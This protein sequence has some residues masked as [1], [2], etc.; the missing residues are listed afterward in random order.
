MG[1]C[2]A[3][4]VWAHLARSGLLS[5]FFACEVGASLSG[6][7]EFTRHQKQLNLT[8]LRELSRRFFQRG[9]SLAQRES[10]ELMLGAAKACDFQAKLLAACPCALLVACALHFS[11]DGQNVEQGASGSNWAHAQTMKRMRR[12]QQALLWASAACQGREYLTW[13]VEKAVE[14]YISSSSRLSQQAQSVR[15]FVEDSQE[16]ATLTDEQ[17]LQTLADAAAVLDSEG[18]EWWPCRGTLIALLRHGRRSGLLSNGKL[19]VVDHDVDI[20]VGIPS[21]AEW[22]LVRSSIVEK[23]VDRGWSHCF[24]RYSV[25]AQIGDVGHWLAR[26]DLFLCLRTDPKVTLDI[27]TYITE[28]PLAYAQKY[29]LQSTALTAP[30]CWIARDSTFRGNQGRL[31]VSSIRP[32]GRCKAGSFSVPC[33]RKPLDTLRATMISVNFTGSC[34]AWPDVR[35]RRERNLYG[36]DQADWLSKGLTQEDVDILKGRAAH[37]HQAGY[38]SMTPYLGL[39]SCRRS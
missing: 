38:M 36:S 8:E 27:A 19:D 29:C 11:V 28:G 2:C 16:E 31:R 30:V 22:S 15:D 34:V 13:P 18:L 25:S 12:H 33:P 24:E 20:M 26:G 39:S 21:H 14:V 9:R 5:L 17:H 6:C 37:L 7:G 4:A 35:E 1:P 10:A 3:M 32:L 23:L